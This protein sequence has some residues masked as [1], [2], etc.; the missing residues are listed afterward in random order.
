[1]LIAHR[2][3][4]STVHLRG[5]D[6]MYELYSVTDYSM[7][8]GHAAHGVGVLDTPTVNVIGYKGRGSSHD[9][10]TTSTTGLLRECSE[11]HYHCVIASWIL[12]T[13]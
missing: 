12:Q 4:E 7:N 6:P 1:M 13:L 9:S 8:L 2:V 11:W 5:D 3:V 10:S